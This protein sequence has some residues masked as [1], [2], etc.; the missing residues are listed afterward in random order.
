MGWVSQD[1]SDKP[2]P[3]CRRLMARIAE[4]EKRVG[5][6]ENLLA[7]ALRGAKRQA[8][9]FSKGRPKD[10]PKPPG[11]KAGPNYGPKAYRPNPDAW[12]EPDE[13]IDVPPPTDCPHC[14]GRVEEDNE[15]PLA[16]QYQVE[17]PRRPIHRRFDLHVGRCARCG[18]RVQGRD[19]RQTSDAVGSAGSQLGPDAQAAVALFK[20]KY[21]L[22]YG[23]IRG[24]FNDFFGVSISRGG[25]AQIVLRTARRAKGVYLAIGRIVRRA[26]IVYPDETGWKVNGRLQWLWVFVTHTATLYVIRPCRGHEVPEEILGADWAGSMTHDGWSPYDFFEQARHQQC[27]THLLGRA[28]TLLETATRGAVQ[29]PRKVKALFQNALALRDRRDAA[30]ISPQ[31][32]AVARGRLENRLDDLLDGRFSNPHNLRF[33][34]HL[35]RHRDQLFT[36]LYQPGIK[37]SNWPA[38][39]AIRPAVVNRKVFGGNR[40]EAG[41]RAQEILASLF[42]TCAQRGYEAMN[43][44]SQLLRLP[45]EH[46]M[47]YIQNLLPVPSG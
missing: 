35:A 41:G 47:A 29:F 8:A 24:I 39:Q 42:A 32:L 14:G 37:A 40:T 6:L 43:Y 46:R 15:H 21:G 9:P 44:L 17:I 5:E 45:P 22:S 30:A 38:E 12:R 36:F 19:P 28:R 23:D 25:A 20:N 10:D 31:G 18:R 11:R 16:H 2:C 34:N 1:S 26:I 13:I 27:V 4:L 33:R 3:N 7:E